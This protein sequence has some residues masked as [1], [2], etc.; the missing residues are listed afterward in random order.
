MSEAKSYAN[1]ATANSYFGIVSE[2][3]ASKRIFNE[4]KALDSYSNV[5]FSIVQF[6]SSYGVWP[7]QLTIVSHAFKRRR[8]VDGHCI[9]IRFPPHRVH[10]IGIDPPGM[11]DGSNKDAIQGVGEA[12]SQWDRDPHGKG[13]VLSSKRIQRNP[14]SVPQTLFPNDQERSRSGVHCEI[15][16]EGQEYLVDGAPQPWSSES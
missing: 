4:E 3:I 1:L 8:L 12:I 15:L 2:D 7:R 14:W 9:A 13:H 16:D 10:F 5:L 6:W 11:M